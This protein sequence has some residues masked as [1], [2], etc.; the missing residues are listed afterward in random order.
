M[1]HPNIVPVHDLGVSNT[2]AVYY[3]MT[4]IR[5][6][7]LK[8]VLK[9]LAEGEEN[10]VRKYPLGSL[11]TI[12]QKACDAVAFAHSKGVVHRDLK[13]DNIMI[14]DFGE[15]LV[16]DWGLAKV[17]QG[18]GDG[19]ITAEVKRHLDSAL[20]E[21]YEV[22]GKQ[23]E[24]ASH[25][26]SHETVN[27][28]VM[29]TPSY[30]APEQATGKNDLID[31]RTDMYTLG[32]VLYGILTLDVP[33][34]ANSV[35]ELI[36]MK[37]EGMIDPPD[38]YNPDGKN[39]R[40]LPHCPGG[41][42]PRALAAITMKALATRRIDR[43]GRVAELQEDLE[44]YQ[45][46]FATA[47]E[48]AGSLLLLWLMAKRR[49]REASI[50]AASLLVI[51]AIIVGFA[52]VQMGNAKRHNALY[53][54]QR[55]L[56]EDLQT[57]T[58]EQKRISHTAAPE[59]LTKARSLVET[60]AWKEAMQATMV[61]QTLDPSL[62]DAKIMEARLL[63]ANH[64]FGKAQ[65]LLD[66]IDEEDLPI[67]SRAN[68]HDYLKIAV[69]FRRKQDRRG[70][71]LSLGE[72]LELGMQLEAIGDLPA[73]ARTYRE[74]KRS[75]LVEAELEIAIDSALQIVKMQNVEVRKLNCRSTTKGERVELNLGSNPELEDL[76]G[77][78]DLPLTHLSLTACSRLKNLDPLRGMPLQELDLTATAVTVL[79]P[80]ENLPLASLILDR[81][82]VRKLLPLRR[83]SLRK[84]SIKW[85]VLDDISDLRELSLRE[86]NISFC[87]NLNDLRPLAKCRKL[88]RLELE[89]TGV[90]S[91]K[92]L[93]R[94]QLRYLNCKGTRVRDLAPI[95]N[96]KSLETLLLDRTKI[97]SL[98]PIT[99][100]SLVHASFYLTD[101]QDINPLGG[102]PLQT[103][104]LGKCL[105]LSSVRGLSTCPRLTQLIIPRRARHIDSLK[106]LSKL[107]YLSYDRPTEKASDFWAKYRP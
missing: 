48:Q 63:V 20:G 82:K 18:L 71:V 35:P 33:L 87:G 76:S 39:R 58:A 99:T 73:A 94:L 5:G 97:T 4:Y 15:V 31:A 77:L 84:L 93:E 85:G 3:T 8:Q 66:D 86:L 91:L 36:E 78:R 49:W 75:A 6:V 64:A 16:M 59:F 30:M 51:L 28:G 68:Y 107:K 105:R 55:R 46:G 47:A 70:G 11:L 80:I 69:A 29:G 83:L 72:R 12:F 89:S 37:R 95:R 61:A 7:T 44:A 17:I 40:A 25:T 56:Y 79:D 2:G 81:T 14:G 26:P 67:G 22:I 52:V 10:A 65:T 1:E 19:T 24:T 54:E 38:S 50:L 62:L 74:T 96:M 88:Q 9:D 34:R 101:I 103:L 60:N 100:L 102:M 21:E 92:P 13:P 27:G 90:Y 43:Y 106:T 57:A 32:G 98:N 41:R 104:N 42:V 53:N 45:G 23:P